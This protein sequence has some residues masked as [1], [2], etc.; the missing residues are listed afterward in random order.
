M[1]SLE[2]PCFFLYLHLLLLD[3]ASPRSSLTR[4]N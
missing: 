1:L 3:L 4:G 2:L